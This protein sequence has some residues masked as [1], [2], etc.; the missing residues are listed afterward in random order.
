MKF[1]YENTNEIYEG[2]VYM[3]EDT[4]I[5]FESNSEIETGLDYTVSLGGNSRFL[6]DL[7]HNTGRCGKMRCFMDGQSV[8]LR[9]LNI[10]ENNKG[11]LYFLSDEEM[12]AYSGEMYFPFKNMCYYDEKNSVI[13]LGNPD[14]QGDT[15]EFLSNTFAVIGGDK[16]SAIF[17]KV[18]SLNDNIIV[19][20]GK[21]YRKHK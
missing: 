5:L 15:I 20:K 10:P 2:T 13:C 6:I 14:L 9:K 4:S 16:L 12:T 1:Y 7:S 18:K 3:T 21:F 8:F 11:K 19:Q 17:M